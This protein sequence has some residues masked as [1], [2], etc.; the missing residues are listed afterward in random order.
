V[1]VGSL[2]PKQLRAVLTWLDFHD[3]EIRAAYDAYAE[4]GEVIKVK[5][6]E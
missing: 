2:P 3:D 6:L 5:G 4:F 1:L